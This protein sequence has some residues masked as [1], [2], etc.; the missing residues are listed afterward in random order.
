MFDGFTQRR[1]RRGESI[2]SNT[3]SSDVV[4]SLTVF[5]IDLSTSH[6]SGECL[7]GSIT[8]QTR[9]TTGKPT[10][11]EERINF[12]CRHPMFRGGGPI[13]SSRRATR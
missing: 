10:I 4:P 3:Q 13:F 6:E 7:I 9:I 1:V 12:Q 5:N 11:W 8:F 2:K